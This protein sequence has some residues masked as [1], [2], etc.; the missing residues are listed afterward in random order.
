MSNYIGT[1]VSVGNLVALE[2]FFKKIPSNNG[3]AFVVIQHLDLTHIGIMSGLLQRMRQMK[4]L[5]AT[6]MLRI[7]PNSVY[8]IPLIKVCT[9]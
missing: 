3:I 8:V 5:Q 9:F 6:D 7:K 2:L 1:D 4:V